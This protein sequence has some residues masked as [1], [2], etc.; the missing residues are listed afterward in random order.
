MTFR[1]QVDGREMEGA[2]GEVE[3]GGQTKS[4]VGPWS[5]T[6]RQSRSHL[7]SSILVCQIVVALLSLLVC[8]PTCAECGT[9]VRPFGRWKGMCGKTSNYC[10]NGTCTYC[11]TTILLTN[12]GAQ[13]KRRLLK[14]EERHSGRMRSSC[15]RDTAAGKC[16]ERKSKQD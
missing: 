4:V 3:I 15:A 2:A 9:A 16:T 11:Q 12:Q 14:Y 10:T 1:D 5:L 7:G 8:V 13:E 6:A